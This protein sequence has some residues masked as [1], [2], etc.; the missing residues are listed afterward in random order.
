MSLRFAT[1][2]SVKSSHYRRH[3]TPMNTHTGRLALQLVVD[4]LEHWDLHQTLSILKLETDVPE[5]DLLSREELESMV[6]SGTDVGGGGGETK[7]PGG[8]PAPVMLRVR[9]DATVTCWSA[10]RTWVWLAMRWLLR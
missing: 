9:F 10:T 5:E 3:T 4:F 7:T 1:P 2:R 6:A 8:K